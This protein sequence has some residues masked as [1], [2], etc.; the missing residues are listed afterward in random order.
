MFGF[1]TPREMLRSFEA[2]GMFGCTSR[3]V[4][5]AWELIS[6]SICYPRGDE[7]NTSLSRFMYCTHASLPVCIRESIRDSVCCVWLSSVA[8]S[9]ATRDD[10]TKDNMC[11]LT[12]SAGI[13]RPPS[14]RPSRIY[15]EYRAY[16][17]RL[18]P[19]AMTPFSSKKNSGLANP[20]WR[21]HI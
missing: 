7:F 2:R 8:R 18:S 15:P 21:M 16:E 13:N 9:F 1:F 19:R 17:T 10:S 11:T 14:S 4:S 6:A 20:R 3:T 5:Y 12:I